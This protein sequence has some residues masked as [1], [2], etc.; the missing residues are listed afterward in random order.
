VSALSH[1][2]VIIALQAILIGCDPPEAPSPSETPGAQPTVA[3]PEPLPGEPL[4]MAPELDAPPTPDAPPRP[5]PS[6][7][8]PATA[9]VGPAGWR[10]FVHEGLVIACADGAA[11]KDGPDCAGDMQIVSLYRPFGGEVRLE[12][13]AATLTEA[14]PAPACP[15]SRGATP[16]GKP[17]RLPIRRTMTS[18]PLDNNTYT[19]LVAE[20]TGQAKP[21]LTAL[22]R[23]DLDEDG[24]AEVIFA[25]DSHPAPD[26]KPGGASMSALA[27]RALGPSGAPETMFVFQRE[28]PADPAD[29]IDRV[30]GTLLGFTDL[31]GDGALDI[32][33]EDAH[34]GGRELSVWRL[35]AGAIERLGGQRCGS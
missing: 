12:T 18:L 29:P 20:V 2:G 33:V 6:T 32:V 22:L 11:S 13:Q 21:K 8:A 1:I 35:R 28:V 16:S 9:Q 19:R 34:P 31:D 15:K 5:A 17:S 27:L 23:I 10:A 4:N 30:R 26:A 3:E 25:S 7:P 14:S 24:N